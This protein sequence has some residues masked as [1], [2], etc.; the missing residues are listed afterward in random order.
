M[1]LPRSIL[2]RQGFVDLDLRPSGAWPDD[3]DGEIF[4]TTSDLRTAPNHAFFGDGALL[5][6]S[7]RPGTHGAAP[8]RFAWRTN[9]IDTPSQ[10]L[11]TARP[12]V[13]ESTVLGSRSPF[14][15]S[16]AANTAPLPWG[17]RLFTTWDAGRPVE[18]D[19]LDLTFV[20]EVG[21]RDDWAPAIDAPVL[22]L[23]ASTAH[24]VI[25]PDRGCMWTVSLDPIAGQVQL[26]RY[27]GEGSRVQRWPVT[28]G[29]VPQSMH[30][31]TQTR[32]WL[33]L[34]DCAFRVDPA[35]LFGVG[36]RSV[37][38]FTDEPVHL[39]RKDAVEA[40]P[41]G[42]PVPATSFRVG[43]EVMH[44][45]AR[46]DDRDGIEVLFEHT[47][48]TDLAMHLRADDLDAFGRRV[49][50]DL[51]G[52]YSHPMHATVVSVLRFDPESGQVTERA[53]MT[54]P[55]RYHSTQLSAL[56]WSTE[57]ISDPTAHHLL[58]SG[59]RPE[60]ISQRAVQLYGARLQ[61][62]PDHEIP[63]ALVTL[64][65]QS[66]K[67]LSDWVWPVDEYPS[68]PTF[69]PRQAG[70]ASPATSRFAGRAPGG[71]DGYVVVPVLSDDGFRIDVFDAAS[72]ADGPVA[73]LSAPDH[74]TVPFILHA[75]W[76]PRAVMAPDVE[77]LRF[78]DELSDWR[79][80]ELPHDLARVAR[81]VAAVLG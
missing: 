61:P 29:Q 10:R 25:D 80:A 31:I 43:P 69:V 30:T 67:P 22:P 58:C 35:E 26:I 64:D 32:D 19:P 48:D 54:E 14:G 36:E 53:S 34:A 51:A 18:V 27:D 16:N 55:E 71:H 5:R 24:P 13:F 40:T 68:S 17:D 62:F 21:H 45:Y 65:R 23:I 56:D 70:S 1:P 3:L 47:P 11:R 7:L 50:P 44:Y 66:L 41:V 57:G 49:D 28:G 33:I 75:A 12:D 74:E 59:F 15:Y 9:M 42:Q 38:N 37:T 2:A 60:A 81:E 63:S 79:L 8:D 6:L 77:R 76:M 46:Y 72:V 78:A 20:A 73:T 52:M 4:I 39:I